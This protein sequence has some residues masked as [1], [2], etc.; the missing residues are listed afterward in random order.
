M[1][2]AFNRRTLATR[3]LVFPRHGLPLPA[4]ISSAG[5]ERR[6]SADYDWHG[7]KRGDAGVVLFQYTLRGSGRLRVASREWTVRR[8]EAMLLHFP[9]DNR[10]WLPTDAG[11]PWEFIYLCMHGRE[12]LRI[13]REAE[14]RLGPLVPLAADSPA[15]RCASRI[16][17]A[18]CRDEISSAAQSAALALELAAHLLAERPPA[19]TGFLAPHAEAVARARSFADHHLPDRIGVEE[20][21]RAAGLSR[22]HFSRLFAAEVG[23]SPAA[24][25]ATRRVQAAAQ[26]LLA[27]TLSIKEIAARC[28]FG[29]IHTFGKAFHRH[30]GT[31][32]GRYRRSGG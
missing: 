10:Y 7:L 13:W 29:D 26:L 30:T 32:P 15:V 18:A 21:A 24:W 20:L 17:R 14:S 28:G 6:D 8:G 12:L 3:A 2:T 23:Q 19:S 22:Y 5:H 25:L 11:E 16:V 31:P 9:A 27:S 4:G 1:L